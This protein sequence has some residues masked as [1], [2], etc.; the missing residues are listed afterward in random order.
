MTA[1]AA[2]PR[3]R[4]FA[5]VGPA[6]TIEGAI[7]ESAETPAAIA[8]VCHPHPLHGGSMDNKVVTTLSRT[9]AR[10]GMVGV[11]FNFRG[12]GGSGGGYDG[13]DG[14]LADALAI[15]D[16]ATA[17]FGRGLPLVLAGFSFGGAI[18][19]RAAS[20]RS[21][22]TLITVA[23]A[24]DRIPAAT[25][26]PH[27]GWLLV[28]GDADTIVSPTKVGAWIDSRARPPTQVWLE[29]VDHFFHGQLGALSR[30]VSEFMRATETVA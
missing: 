4:P 8:V 22:S 25:E 3:I 17:E 30:A 21:T 20:A 12:V 2:V 24:V 9:F 29:G 10:L 13:G 19:Y 27:S 14:E 5:V 23:P 15:I 11:R 18:A 26:E 7:E 6:G 16:W 1:T 28:Q